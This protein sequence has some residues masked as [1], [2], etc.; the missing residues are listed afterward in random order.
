[1]L[2]EN[3]KKD[4]SLIEEGDETVTPVKKKKQPSVEKQFLSKKYLSKRER[5]ERSSRSASRDVSHQSD[6]SESSDVIADLCNLSQQINHHR[7][8]SGER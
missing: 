5:R 1:M 7:R 6:H 8:R 3:N 2:N 4:L